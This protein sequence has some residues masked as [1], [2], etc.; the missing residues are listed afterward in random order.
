MNKLLISLLM[1]AGIA[2]VAH[3]DGDAKAGQ[4]LTAICA[5]CHGADGNS[6]APNFPKLA[7]QG[8]EYLLKQMMDIKAGS[9][10]VPEMTGLLNNLSDQ[11][12]ANVAAYFASQKVAPGAAKPELAELGATIYIAGVADKGVPAC[13]ACHSPTG[14]GNTLARFPHLGGQHAT[15]TETQLKNFRIGAR[16]NDP[17]MMMR[18]VAARMSDAEIAAVASYIQGL[19]PA[20]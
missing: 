14:S 16:N 18:D 11:D 5:A 1:S 10:Q 6:M 3:A 9:R 15:Y 17:S 8:E 13:Q 19:R 7:G 12:M 20:E 4:P 2:G